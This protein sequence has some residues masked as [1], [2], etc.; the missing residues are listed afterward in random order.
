MSWGSYCTTNGYTSSTTTTPLTLTSL[1]AN[2]ASSF[3]SWNSTAGMPNACGTYTQPA[4]F[5]SVAGVA[6][7]TSR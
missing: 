3:S 7:S 6:T 4:G 1:V 5:Y 2:V